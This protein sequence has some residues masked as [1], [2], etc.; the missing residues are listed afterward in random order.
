MFR[1]IEPPSRP[2]MCA[3]S[4]EWNETRTAMVRLLACH[5]S[6]VT[7][8]LFNEGMGQFDARA[9][10]EHIHGIDPTRPIDAV[11]GW[12]DQHCGDSSFA[13]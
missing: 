8:T 1:T 13:A 10:A 2:P 3:T 5:P 11:S 6:I 12:F 7:W 9:A 4:S